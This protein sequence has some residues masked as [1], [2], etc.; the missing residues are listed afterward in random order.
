M[1]A[2]KRFSFKTTG[3]FLISSNHHNVQI[4]G[5]YV[6]YK[7]TWRILLNFL[8]LSSKSWTC[9]Q[10]VMWKELGCKKEN[11][12]IFVLGSKHS[13]V[14]AYIEYIKH[15]LPAG[16]LEPHIV[17]WWVEHKPELRRSSMSGVKNHKHKK[18][19]KW[20]SAMNQKN[21]YFC[22][23]KWR[24]GIKTLKEKDHWTGM[25]LKCS[26][27]FF[28]FLPSTKNSVTS[29]A[30]ATVRWRWVMLKP[31]WTFATAGSSTFF[32]LSSTL[33]LPCFKHKSSLDLKNSNNPCQGSFDCWIET[34]K[35]HWI[36][37]SQVQ[38][39]QILVGSVCHFF[40]C[41]VL[42]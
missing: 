16:F 24:T 21:C 28:N 1:E 29:Y 30:S 36:L 10:K 3:P 23:R 25:L 9:L 26:L 11:L 8:T 38:Q 31:S 22:C 39:P 13:I 27:L 5:R 40:Q 17:Q 18:R 4:C 15:W 33:R 7:K 37:I 42:K 2:P 20:K 41:W 14:L 6:W 19:R 35:S 12:W 32:T 34:D